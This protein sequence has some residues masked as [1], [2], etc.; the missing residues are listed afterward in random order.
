MNRPTARRGIA[1]TEVVVATCVFSIALSGLGATIVAQEKLMRAI[2]RRTYV[3]TPIHCRAD[4]YLDDSS[5]IAADVHDTSLE[6][7]NTIEALSCYH[8]DKL[9]ADGE[10]VPVHG[11]VTA[12]D[13]RRD[14][15][16]EGRSIERP[17]LINLGTGT[18]SSSPTRFS[19]DRDVHEVSQSFD[20]SSLEVT[21]EP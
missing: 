3:L 13:A 6:P 2:E 9:A 8:L 12:I 15:W 18:G 5:H 20:G 11:L 19:V 16:A 4:L 10:T 1:Y 7:R 14:E 17:Q 21:L